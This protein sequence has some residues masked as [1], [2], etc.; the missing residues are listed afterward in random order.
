MTIAAAAAGDNPHPAGLPAGGIFN[1]QPEPVPISGFP[2]MNTSTHWSTNTKLIVMLAVLAVIGF[3]LNRFQ[4]LIMPLIMAVILAYLLNPIVTVLVKYLR[5]S[6]TIAVLILYGVLILLLIGLVSGAGFLLQQ[7]L[8]GMLNSVLDFINTLPTWIESITAKPVV[9]GPFTFDLSA[10]NVSLLQNALLP[11]ARDG[12]GQITEWMTGA[13]SGVASFLGW[14]A[15]AF[16]IAFYLLHDMDA[17]QKG[18]LRIIP[19]SYTKDA[20]RLLDELVPIWNAFLRGQMLLSLIMGLAIGLVMVLLGVRYAL[21]IGLMAAVAEFIPN[22]GANLVGIA[23]VLIALFQPSNWLGLSPI[24]Y[25]IVVGAAGG[26]MQQ[27]ESY[28]LIPR[29]MGDQLKLHPVILLIGALVGL[30]LLGLPG[31]LLSAPIIATARLF[32]K[33]IRAK[34]FNLPPWPDLEEERSLTVKAPLVQIRPARESDQGDMLQVTAQMWE[35]HDYIPRVWSEW[36][37][38]RKGILAAAEVD[39]RMVGFG[40]LT[41][42]GPREWWLEGLRVHPRYQGLKIGSQLTEHLIEKW[43]RRGGGVIRLAASSE[44]LPIHRLCDRLG[45]QRVG[46]CRLMAASS[47]EHGDCEYLPITGADA[48]EATAL[49]KNTA[50]AWELPDLVNDGWRWIRYTE[51]RL[52]EFILRQRAWWWRE[53]SGILLAYDSDHDNTP[54]LE[55]AAAIA[56]VETLTPMLRQLRVLAKKQKADR[57]AWVMPDNLRAAEAAERAGFAATGDARLWIFERSDPSAS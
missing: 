46:V 53:R 51:N 47:A 39:G 6:R 55:V 29:V 32:A 33:Y 31:L 37:D 48:K 10:A 4:V 36:L 34:L 26:M 19:D 50:A 56:P 54:S 40:K 22:F 18:L 16:I 43:K 23:A 20:Q 35:G 42:L 13:A 38:D 8:S 11:T 52:A 2:S 30:T 14:T 7:Q 27:L 41:R 3:F 12:I 17:L 21:I 9:I 44:R 15:F 28:F 24:V 49:W 57:V 1:P 5:T 45:F 25:A